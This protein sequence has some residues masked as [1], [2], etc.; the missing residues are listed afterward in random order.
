MF[1]NIQQKLKTSAL[2]EYKDGELEITV[3]T[4]LSCK[5]CAVC[6]YQVLRQCNLRPDAHN[7]RELADKFPLTL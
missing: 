1:R 7:V 6:H 3:K 4:C 2:D 5:N